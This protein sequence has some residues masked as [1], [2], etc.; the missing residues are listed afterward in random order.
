ML[1]K[2]LTSVF[3]A[4]PPV[5]ARPPEQ[6]AQGGP[7]RP[8]PQPSSPIT[9]RGAGPSVSWTLAATEYFME[10]LLKIRHS[11]RLQHLPDLDQGRRCPSSER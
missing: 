3:E 8:A 7:S 6:Q 5:Y 1:L 4:V 9:D 10:S 2:Q 11:H